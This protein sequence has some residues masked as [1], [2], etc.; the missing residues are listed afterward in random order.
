MKNQKAIPPGY[1]TVGELAK[2]MNT[3]VRTLQYYDKEG[4]LCPPA[5]SEGGRRLYTSKDIVWL[6]QILSMKSLGFSLADIK[7]RLVSLETPQEVAAALAGQA[8]AIREKITS[9]TQTLDTVEK[10]REETLRMQTVD[11]SKYAAIVVNLQ[12]KNEFYGLI[13]HFDDKTLAHLHQR[14]TMES[15]TAVL[16]TLNRLISEMEALQKS[17]ACPESEQGEALAK[18]WWAMVTEFTGGDMSI[19]PELIKMGG[20]AGMGSEDWNKKWS[21]IEPFLQQ[22]LSAYFTK[23]GYN[24]FAGEPEGE[25]E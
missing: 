22:A 4:L 18:Q 24:P 6:H 15:G 21:G 1:I 11:F 2:K 14:F 3:T 17:G 23:I 20:K 8:A 7:D 12:M 9:L 5:E 10:L 19:L 16:N 25:T 13:K